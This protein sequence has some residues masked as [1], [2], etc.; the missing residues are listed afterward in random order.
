MDNCI[1]AR[2]YAREF[3]IA[4][5][6]WSI[7]V[8]EILA[9]VRNRIDAALTKR[10]PGSLCTATLHAAE[11]LAV[12]GQVSDASALAK[13]AYDYGVATKN[14]EVVADAKCTLAKAA[15]VAG[16]LD[17]AR[18]LLTDNI[19]YYKQRRPVDYD[20]LVNSYVALAACC[21]SPASSHD[22]VLWL[23]RALRLAAKTEDSTQWRTLTR[24]NLAD[25][26]RRRGRH[27]EADQLIQ[28]AVEIARVSRGSVFTRAQMLLDLAKVS[29]DSGFLDRA[30]ELA[31]RAAS[32]ATGAAMPQL[33]VRSLE[34]QGEILARKGRIPESLARYD[35]GLE[36]AQHLKLTKKVA[37]LLNRSGT[38]LLG[39]SQ[40]AEAERRLGESFSLHRELR[41][42]V[43]MGS[44][45]MQLGLLYTHINR[46]SEAMACFHRCHELA[47][48]IGDRRGVVA[49]LTNGANIH[50]KETSS[51]ASYPLAVEMLEKALKLARRL[52]D[53]QLDAV[54]L[55]GLGN[56]RAA[57]GEKRAAKRCYSQALSAARQ[58]GDSHAV[59]VSIMNLAMLDRDMGMVGRALPLYRKGL[60]VAHKSRAIEDEAHAYHHIGLCYDIA[61]EPQKALK[62]YL[63]QIRTL[64][65]ARAGLSRAE[66]RRSFLQT[67]LQG[68]ENAVR[69]CLRLADRRRDASYA[70][71]AFFLA[72]EARCHEL[73]EALAL[74]PD[75]VFAVLPTQSVYPA[76]VKSLLR[77]LQSRAFDGPGGNRR[78][79][80]EFFLGRD[81][82]A[83]FTLRSGEAHVSAT[84][85]PWNSESISD[86]IYAARSNDLDIVPDVFGGVSLPQR[87]KQ[88]IP[89][90][91]LSFSATV[92]GEVRRRAHP[93]DLLL[94]IPHAYLNLIPW[95]ALV[96]PREKEQPEWRFLIE[97]HPIVV[98]T[99][100]YLIGITKPHAN[101]KTALVVGNP[102]GSGLAFAEQ[103]AKDVAGLFGCEPLL[104][105]S[106][107]KAA[108]LASI[109]GKDVL[110]FACHGRFVGFD[111]Q[112]TAISL[113]DG[114]L[115]TLAELAD[116]IDWRG[117][118]LVTLSACST[119]ARFPD[120]ADD[121][122]SMVSTLLAAGCNSVLAAL[123]PVNDGPAATI[124]SSFYQNWLQN[125]QTKAN[126][127]RGALL[128]FIEAQRQHAV[129]STDAEAPIFPQTLHPSFWAGFQLWGDWR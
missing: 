57:L 43:G 34:L 96:E 2:E 54:I 39:A 108:V 18:P 112:K 21:K 81:M 77:S 23:R 69:C 45:L 102:S 41:D 7:A 109:P 47:E 53:P 99:S 72:E 49:A 24:M 59:A 66:D 85:L 8:P 38:L 70:D 64:R 17:R 48:S 101:A 6:K 83:L 19:R 51:S 115:L 12:A 10:T 68:Y 126:A 25:A 40:F 124:M 28:E 127:L 33:E 91:F 32:L 111:Q 61:D 46:F 35:R 125:G 37:V 117:R 122:P 100:S 113:A 1:P 62:A 119:G 106:A 128:S 120:R 82:C 31:E 4:L 114:E 86:V 29:F 87:L 76:T 123:W 98:I 73:R 107:T 14:A 90:F 84:L 116:G 95:A 129:V 3:E 121:E 9:G 27:A 67:R 104:A 92:L 13:V 110:H 5:R 36:V 60:V 56:A 15:I 22:E 20:A 78:L 58:A 103:E 42:L 75:N 71:L 30:M 97:D 65:L 118:C 50:S 105:N 63:A 93:G 94:V 11:C 80:L 16:E 44:D 74:T 26:L 55:G 52:R 89:K 88:R 79:L